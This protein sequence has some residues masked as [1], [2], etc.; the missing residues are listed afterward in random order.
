MGDVEANG[1]WA[2][3]ENIYNINRDRGRLLN[4]PAVVEG[5]YGKGKAILSLIHFDTPDDANGAVVLK[6][7]MGISG[8]AET[9]TRNAE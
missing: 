8:G 6:E 9:G 5:T 7:L 3:L 2:E 4:E 1:G